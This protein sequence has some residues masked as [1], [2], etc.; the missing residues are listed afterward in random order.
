MDIETFNQCLTYAASLGD[1][2]YIDKFIAVA[3]T[4]AGIIIGFTLNIF[5]ESIKKRKENSDK[6]ICIMEDVKRT[7]SALGT[8]ITESLRMID[9]TNAGEDVPGHRLPSKIESMLIEEYFP[10]VAHSYTADERTSI[11]SLINLLGE[12]NDQLTRFRGRTDQPH[13][14]ILLTSLHNLNNAAYYCFALCDSFVES[15]KKPNYNQLIEIADRL[16][17]SSAFVESLRSR[18]TEANVNK[19]PETK[20]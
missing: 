5:R 12:T 20:N 8:I 19:N 4:L 9:A 1:G 2:K 10:S 6:K 16:K 7:Q 17:I 3:T 11:L 18:R 15:G 14:T 13:R